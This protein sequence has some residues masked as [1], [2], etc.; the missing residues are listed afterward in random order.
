METRG[1]MYVDALS[2]ST[3]ILLD[4]KINFMNKSSFWLWNN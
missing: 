3:K 1:I 4:V 2:Q